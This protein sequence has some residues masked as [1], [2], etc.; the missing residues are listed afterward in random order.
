MD[1]RMM[2]QFLIPRMQ[3]AEEADV[4]PKV[5]LVASHCQQR[6]GAGPKQQSVDLALILQGQRRQLAGQ[7]EHH[8]GI[9]D[10]QQFPAARLQPPV[11]CVGLALRTM[12]VP[13]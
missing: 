5:S 4:C 9:G 13:T 10:R 11:P 1:M 3:H 2:L 6:L 7:G 8:V 12:P